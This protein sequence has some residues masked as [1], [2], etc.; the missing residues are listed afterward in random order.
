LALGHI[1]EAPFECAQL[2]QVCKSTDECGGIF[3]VG[4]LR[5]LSS[6]ESWDLFKAASLGKNF[7]KSICP[8]LKV[9]DETEDFAF[10]TARDSDALN[11]GMNLNGGIASADVTQKV[12]RKRKNYTT[13]TSFEHFVGVFEP[14]YV[15]KVWIARLPG[16]ITSHLPGEGGLLD[17]KDVRT[18]VMRIT[19]F[20]F[21]K[22]QIVHA[23][24]PACAVD[25]DTVIKRIATLI[26]VNRAHSLMY[27]NPPVKFEGDAAVAALVTKVVPPHLISP[28]TT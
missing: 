12:E 2:S 26:I 18:V 24:L 1:L 21:L 3:T 23:C 14:G 19:T 27:G 25:V 16:M 15:A 7:E 6:A 17:A 22:H 20:L 28:C 13:A 11:G 5:G 8:H 9:D 10:L 4:A